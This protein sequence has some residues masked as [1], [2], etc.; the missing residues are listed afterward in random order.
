MLF[1]QTK[2]LR[3]IAANRHHSCRGVSRRARA[4]VPE[5]ALARPPVYVQSRPVTRAAAGR[6]GT[7][8]PATTLPG[9]PPSLSPALSRS[10]GSAQHTRAALTAHCNRG[11]VVY[12]LYGGQPC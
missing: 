6:E 8:S 5:A 10:L 12:R 2:H 9:P 7:A 4:G 3:C 1:Q 11:R